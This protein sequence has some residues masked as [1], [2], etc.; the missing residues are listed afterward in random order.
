MAISRDFIVTLLG[1]GVPSPTLDRFGASA[2]VQAGTETL[3]FD[4]GR[5]TLQRLYQLKVNLQDARLLFL[6]HLHS[7]HSTGIP[8]LWLTPPVFASRGFGRS[9][10]LQVYGPVGTHHMMHHLQEAYSA[11][12]NAMTSAD[13]IHESGYGLLYEEFEEGI[14]YQRN[15]VT[16]SAFLVEHVNIKPAYGFKVEYDGRVAVLSGDTTYCE[17]LIKHAEGAD[18]L[19]QEVAMVPENSQEIPEH[20]RGVLNWHTTPEQAAKIFTRAEPKLAVYTHLALFLGATEE[21]LI[22]RTQRTYGGALE[23]GYDLASFEV[24]RERGV[25]L[26]R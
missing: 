22:N 10:A 8:D 3:L 18:L 12:T 9:D 11:D 13:F 26:Q 20:I 23:V 19:I 14:V 1:T 17:N 2:L 5:G 7:D 4:C 21:E 16:V 6:T 15:G 25:F 24:G